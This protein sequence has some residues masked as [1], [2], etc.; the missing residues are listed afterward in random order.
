[1]RTGQSRPDSLTTRVLRAIA[2]ALLVLLSACATTST[3]VATV[4]PERVRAEESRQR[5]IVL[6]EI[7]AQQARLDSIAYPLLIAAADVCETKRGAVWGF[8]ANAAQDYD[9]DWRPAAEANGILSDLT[10]TH[11]IPGSPA[12]RAGLLRGDRLVGLNG[13]PLSTR[14]GAVAD[15]A[16]R[17]ADLAGSAEFTY[18]RVGTRSTAKL[19][20]ENGC[21]LGTMVTPQG[22]INAFADGRN[23]IFPWPMMR[24]ADD[25]ELT[26]VIGHEIAHN[27]MGHIEAKR[28]NALWGAL[29]GALGDVALATQGVN[30][31]GY[32]SAEF[33]A[34]GAR[35]FSQDF[36]READYVGMYIL[37]RAG[38][39]LDEA[40]MLWR[41]FA[42]IDPTA[43]AYAST[44]PTTAERFVLLE[45]TAREIE[46]KR[47]AGQ[48]L[49][50]E[51]KKE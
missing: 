39:S 43:I 25:T 51:K 16:A 10:V 49:L 29:L 8:R 20:P 40:P 6:R 32:Y 33:A 30:T 48:P 27:A 15:L 5:E 38:V 17:L 46:R 14:R 11:V 41:H 34:T 23:I 1:M 42:Q 26:V 21:A 4:P 18:E 28:S 35:A 47:A 12:D 24:I 44:H 9:D 45:E 37:A 3:R 50:P 36:E 2:P 31:G 7:L 19:E 13:E 22:G